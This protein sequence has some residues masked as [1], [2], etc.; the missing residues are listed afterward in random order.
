MELVLLFREARKLVT[1]RLVLT[2]LA[3]LLTVVLQAQSGVQILRQPSSVQAELGMTV[4]LSV[5]VDSASSYQWF[6]DGNIVRWAK[7]ATLTLTNC[8]PSRIGDYYVVA[9]N[10]TSSVTSSIATL[11]LK[12]I[13]AG[14]WKGLVG[15]YPF[16]GDSQDESI[17]GNHGTLMPGSSLSTDGIQGEGSVK[18]DGVNGLS[19]GVRVLGSVLNSGQ[20]EY[21]LNI[22]F[23]CTNPEKVHQTLI[24]TDPHAGIGISYNY[25]GSRR[26]GMLLGSGWNWLPVGVV[27]SNTRFAETRWRMVSLVKRGSRFELFVDGVL[28]G[29]LLAS[30]VGWNQ[31]LSLWLGSIGPVF[32][33]ALHPGEVF[34]GLLDDS[35]IYSRALSPGELAQ[36]YSSFGSSTFVAKG[37]VQVV[38]GFVVGAT[39]ADGGSGYTNAPVV[40]I[41]GGGGTGATARATVVNGIVTAITIQN[42]GSGY[43]SVPTLTIAPPPF[44]PRKATAVA[45]IVNGFVVGSNVT[46]GGFGYQAPPAVVLIGGGGSG[47]KAVA[48]VVNGVVTAVSMTNPGNGYTSAPIVRIASPPFSP[49]L[50]VEVSQVKVTLKVVLGRKYQIESTSDMANWSPTGPSFVAEDE[51]LIQEFPVDTVGRF[52]RINQVP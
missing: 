16:N 5:E 50:S 48:T 19:K 37:T 27:Y 29:T 21:T 17:M 24:N 25:D 12:G 26:V 23:K 3:S 35:R 36:L 42:P 8:Q 40:T 39:V 49:S 34:A 1:E 2:L 14:I 45:Q 43:S 28:E 44:P 4:S 38:N 22:W 13:D 47:A 33:G 46:D 30:S 11:N 6:K 32:P 9:G 15:H 7:S 18:I 51:E 10:N 20:E 52:F 31:P 41:S